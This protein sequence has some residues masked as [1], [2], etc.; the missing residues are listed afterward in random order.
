[1]L[2]RKYV[3]A[4]AAAV[5]LAGTGT[6]TALS[7]PDGDSPATAT[8]AAGDAK[9]A[10]TGHANGNAAK[11]VATA[12]SAVPG[13]VTGVDLEDDGGEW[14]LD[15]FG[16][17]G[18]WHDVT[19]DAAGTKVVN[20]HLDEDA[21]DRA[22]RAPQS[23][24]VTVQQAMT[25]ALKTAP[26]QVTEADLEQGHWEIEVRGQNGTHQDVTVDAKTGA[27]AV[28]KDQDADARDADDKASGS[29][30]A[31]EADAGT[32][33]TDDKASGDQDSAGRPGDDK[34]D[35]ADADG[36]GH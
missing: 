1:M 22:D 20:K 5:V 17:D 32:Q 29:Q 31:D 9:G 18:K 10:G 13:T 23:A 28:V 6:A 14:D 21:D 24:P 34:D 11:A 26:G 30:D 36:A 2:K 27:A 33:D 15:V 16:K 7:A 8:S 3:I 4:A 12:V 25:A 35:T 19:V